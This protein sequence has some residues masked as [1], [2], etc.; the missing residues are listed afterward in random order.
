MLP[1]RPV[2]KVLTGK[3]ADAVQFI[4]EQLARRRP[5]RRRPSGM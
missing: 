2:K 4:T 3:V 5:D 1:W